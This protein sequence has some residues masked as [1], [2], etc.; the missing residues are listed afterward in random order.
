MEIGQ[1]RTEAAFALADRLPWNRPRL[2]RLEISTETGLRG[3]STDDGDG[4]G[5]ALDFDV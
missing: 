2:Q 4:L 5:F 1:E 3:G